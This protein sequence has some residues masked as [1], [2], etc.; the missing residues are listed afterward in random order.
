LLDEAVNA[1]ANS[2]NG[3]TF[4]VDDQ[5]AAASEARRLAVEDARTK[6]EELAAA[7][8]LTLGSVVSIAEGAVS[9]MPPP[10]P[11]AADAGMAE[12]QA[13]VPVQPGSSTSVTHVCGRPRQTVLARHESRTSPPGGSWCVGCSKRERANPQVDR[14]WILIR[15]PLRA[16]SRRDPWAASV[17]A[18]PP[19]RV[20]PISRDGEAVV[21]RWT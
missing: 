9:P 14:H 17:I 18:G 15:G 13:A 3:V 2:I 4:S 11:A 12:A 1:G 10:M 6:A 8:G 7:A 16:R 5:T 19:P 20:R 21:V